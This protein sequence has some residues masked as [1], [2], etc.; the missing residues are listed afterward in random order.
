MLRASQWISIVLGC[1]YLQIKP[2]YPPIE[3]RGPLLHGKEPINTSYPIM[4]I[5]NTH[6]PV[7]P[8]R[9]ALK[10]SQ[11]FANAG[12]LELKA[13]GHCTLAAVSFCAI[14]KIQDYLNRGIVPDPPRLERD[15]DW[16]R[17]LAAGEW[18]KCP[19]DEWPWKPFGSADEVGVASEFSSAELKVMAAWKEVQAKSEEIARRMTPPSKLHF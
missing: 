13:E 14:K 19:V 9:Q 3:W 15:A 4:F 16:D 2:E 1:S 7:T 6:D 17:P 12:L 5:G 8:L 18:E 11:R 10:M